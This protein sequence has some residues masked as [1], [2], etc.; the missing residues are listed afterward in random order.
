[1]T[2]NENFRSSVSSSRRKLLSMLAT[3]SVASSLSMSAAGAEI[4]EEPSTD[5]VTT[6]TVSYTDEL[7][8]GAV[9]RDYLDY[10]PTLLH[11]S[12]LDEYESKESLD[13]VDGDDGFFHTVINDVDQIDA[14][15]S[16]D[17][18]GLRVEARHTDWRDPGDLNPRIA[19]PDIN[20][21][22]NREWYPEHR[23][24]TMEEGEGNDGVWI[25]Y[26][27]HPDWFFDYLGDHQG[28][29][30]HLTLWMM[31]EE[32]GSGMGYWVVEDVQVFVPRNVPN[33]FETDPA[34][35][36]APDDAAYVEEAVVSFNYEHTAGGTGFHVELPDCTIG[37]F[38]DAA[39]TGQE[40]IYF[41]HHLPHCAE[42]DDIRF[43]FQGV[44]EY[45]LDDVEVAW[46]LEQQPLEIT[47]SPSDA[48]VTIDGQ[49]A[50]STPH[51]ETISPLEEVDVTLDANG[52]QSTTIEGVM[53]PDSIDV[54]LDAEED[55]ISIDSSPSGADVYLDGSY[56]GTSPVSVTRPVTESYEI[57][58]EKDDYESETIS[59]VSAPASEYVTL[60]PEEATIN[61]TSSPDGANVSLDGSR[62]GSTP[63]SGD[64]PVTESYDLEISKPDYDSVSYEGISAP[65]DI[66]AELEANRE[67]IDIDSVPDG[68]DVYFD[69]D[70]V[71]T[72]PLGESRPVTDSYDVTIEKTGYYTET[73]SNVSAPA[74]ETVT[75]D[76]IPDEPHFEISITGTNSPVEIDDPLEVDVEVINSGDE[77][78]T[79]WIELSAGPL[80]SAGESVQ[81]SGGG[82]TVESF[83][84]PTGP[85]DEGTYTITAES[86]DDSD[87]ESVT[88]TSSDDPVDEYR[89]EDGEVDT[90]NLRDA[91][92]DWHTDE[93]DTELLRETIDGWRSGSS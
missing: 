54:E 20:L 82:S 24:D 93:I 89:N 64:R 43:K 16:F 63:W 80:D 55:T 37:S 49:Y 74:S 57:E 77:S 61:V 32:E 34:D 29:D 13:D 62:V 56:I 86:D 33:S 85:G 26:I 2:E 21:F 40:T 22:Q 53:A 38:A 50:G 27:N 73:L 19:G 76:P 72:T 45:E 70:Y 31:F 68:A 88:I 67:T 51:T 41:N 75:L 52:Y 18:I 28:S 48:T 5:S 15:D 69:G 65:A 59:N 90:D 84:F 12:E 58:V 83:W 42:M 3:G 8:T 23:V 35:V 46:T 87:A 79:Q 47:S 78:D 14:D 66:D 36:T 71:G 30:D 1:M 9:I 81:L 25:V 92:D 39:G 44:G 6:Q 60:D 10:I 11:P 91:I 7:A 4:N 17:R